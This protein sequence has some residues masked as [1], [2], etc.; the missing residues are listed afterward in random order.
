[1]AKSPRVPDWQQDNENK[2]LNLALRMQEKENKKD[3][4]NESKE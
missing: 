2:K 4:W 1:M 3:H